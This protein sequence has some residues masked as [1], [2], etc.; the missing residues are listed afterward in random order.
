[1]KQFLR[2]AS[3]LTADGLLGEMFINADLKIVFLELR[4]HYGTLLLICKV[5]YT[6][7]LEY[8]FS[9]LML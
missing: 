7:V 6:L 4:V 8:Q 2:L 9:H 1:M 5:A 3:M